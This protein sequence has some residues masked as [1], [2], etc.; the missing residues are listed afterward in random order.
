M[1]GFTPTLPFAGGAWCVSLLASTIPHFYTS[2]PDPRSE[3]PT[4]R[5]ATEHRA[6]R[7]PQSGP[8]SRAWVLPVPGRSTVR[9]PV[10]P[11]S[12]LL[13]TS[14]QCSRRSHPHCSHAPRSQEDPG[15]ATVK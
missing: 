13:L 12:R 6:G 15:A 11:L 9:E 7:G 5:P 2:A 14:S 3:I 8:T 10:S 1:L 4:A